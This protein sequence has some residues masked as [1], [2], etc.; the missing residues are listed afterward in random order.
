VAFF[1]SGEEHGMKNVGEDRAMY[2]VIA[3]GKD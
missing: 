2:T 1:S 3:L